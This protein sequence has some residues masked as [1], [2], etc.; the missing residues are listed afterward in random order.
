MTTGCWALANVIAGVAKAL[1]EVRTLGGLATIV[2]V[3]NRFVLEERAC[4]YA[5]RLLAELALGDSASAVQNRNQLRSLGACEAVALVLK[6]HAKSQGFVLV[7]ARDALRHL[8]AHPSRI[9]ILC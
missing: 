6:Q 7:R 5:C 9:S 2:G 3:F 1:D 4:E 8:Q